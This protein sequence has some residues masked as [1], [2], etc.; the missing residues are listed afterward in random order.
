MRG[1]FESKAKHPSTSGEIKSK[2]SVAALRPSC[3]DQAMPKVR[4]RATPQVPF[5][6]EAAAK[7]FNKK[8]QVAAASSEAVGELTKLPSK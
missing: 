4:P 6:Q 8:R 3:Y 7:L 1:G 2:E 5:S